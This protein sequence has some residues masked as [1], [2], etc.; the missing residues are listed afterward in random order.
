MPEPVVRDD[1]T[2]ARLVRLDLPEARGGFYPLQAIYRR[3]D[4][5]G[6]AAAW[7]IQR[8]VSQAA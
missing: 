5:P 2:S 8:F 7:M 4:P 3:Y 1:L 6:P